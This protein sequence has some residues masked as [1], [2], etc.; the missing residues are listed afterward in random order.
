MSDR[1]DTRQFTYARAGVDYARI[2]P[3]KLLAQEA[4]RRTAGA[5]VDRGLSEVDETR[6]ESAYVVDLGAHFISTVTEALGT[7]NLVADALRE[8][9]GRTFYDHI[10]Q[11][12]VATILNDLATVGGVPLCITA[13]WGCGSSDWLADDARMSDLVRGWERACSIAACSWGGGETQVLAGIIDP[14]TAVLGGSAVGLVQPRDRLLLGS[15]IVAGDAMLAADSSGI[16]ANGLTLARAIA[17]ALPEGY[18]TP[19][20]GDPHGRSLGEALLDPTP[21]YGPLVATLQLAG[22]D[23]HYAVHVTGH[24]WRK[25]M[26]AE[27]S[28]TY[29][30]EQVP[31]VPPV[32]R[33]LQQA[34]G[35]SDADAYATFNMGAGYV[36]FVGESESGRAVELAQKAGFTVRRI[37]TV[38]PGP[39]RVVIDPC[40]LAFDDAAMRIR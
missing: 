21:L 22:V 4:A 15:R 5:L 2:D 27:P 6:G 13:Y 19:V 24:G 23:L 36:L 25:L 29:R 10:A 32:L 20:P 1:K 18:R 26:R 7:K 39:K 35:M 33:L 40:H 3:G 37:G 11:D 17:G 28:F 14:R 31:P 12:A 38:Q 8:E 9:H 30:V 16:H 34:G